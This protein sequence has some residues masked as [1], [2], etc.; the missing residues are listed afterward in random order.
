MTTLPSALRPADTARAALRRL[1]ELKLPP[2]PE[3][4]AQ[5]YY[6]I[7]GTPPPQGLAGTDRAPIDFVDRVDDILDKAANVTERLEVSVSSS[8]SKVAASLEHLVTDAMPANVIELLQSMLVTSNAM[9]HQLRASHAELLDARRSLAEIK[10][11]LSDNR[12][13]LETDPLTGT[14]N[15]RALSVILGREIARATRHA[16]PLSVVM[17]D[18]DH[19]KRINDTHGHAVGDAA[20][21]HLTQVAHSILRGNDAFVR[22]GGEEF[23]LVLGETATAGAVYV[24]T[25]LQQVLARQPCQHQERKIRMTFSAGVATLRSGDTET[26]LLERADAAMYAAKRAGRNRV[27]ADD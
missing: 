13:L 2:T 24:A 21:V 5:H 23:V 16:H 15:R 8:G 3:F 27:V 19:F 12:K 25:R 7:L 1:A 26:T 10:A 17:V 11:E 9:Q 14:D 18:I 4:Y 20:L 22:Y 6:A